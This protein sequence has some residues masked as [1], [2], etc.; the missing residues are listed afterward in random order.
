MFCLCIY[1]ASLAAQQFSGIFTASDA[2]LVYHANLSWDE[3]LRTDSLMGLQN[4][5]IQDLATAGI[6]ANRRYW[7]I[8]TPSSQRDTVVVCLGWDDMVQAKRNLA[9]AGWLLYHLTAYALSESDYRVIGVW[10]QGDTAHKI[11]KID[12]REGLSQKTE[13]MARQQFYLQQVEV[14]TTPGGTPVYLPLY[15]YSPLPVR[16]YL[17]YSD[18]PA[19]FNTDWLRRQNSGVRILKF[20]RFTDQG[21]SWLMGVYAPGQYPHALLQQQPQAEFNDRWERFE[22][23]GLQLVDWEVN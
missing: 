22:S 10:R 20:S 8:Y 17:F 2:K 16:N 9:A 6:G 19:V 18:D 12:S 14:F 7:S 13:E 15:H 4:H 1:T 23:E 3:W 21:R 5:R 11:W